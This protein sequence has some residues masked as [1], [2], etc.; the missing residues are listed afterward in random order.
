MKQKVE[1]KTKIKDGT[2]LIRYHY[3]ERKVGAAMSI[4]RII[5]MMKDF[6]EPMRVSG[7]LV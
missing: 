6:M 2:V 5:L 3:I 1:G 7:R 4:S